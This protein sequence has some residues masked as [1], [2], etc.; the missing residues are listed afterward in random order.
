MASR[1]ESSR[2]CSAFSSLLQA[3]FNSLIVLPSFGEKGL[4]FR[5]ISADWIENNW[6]SKFPKS[7]NLQATN[8]TLA[9]FCNYFMHQN[10][11]NILNLI[12]RLVMGLVNGN[13]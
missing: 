1:T 6:I 8:Q 13:L 7:T 11:A 12:F 5:A 4:M 9:L 3:L 2:S 10:N